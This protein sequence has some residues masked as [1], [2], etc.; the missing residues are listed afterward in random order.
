LPT[1]QLHRRQRGKFGFNFQ[2]AM[3]VYVRILAALFAPERCIDKSLGMQRAQGMPGAN[4]THG[5]VCE[6]K[7][8]YEQRHHRSA[9][10]IR[11]SLRDGLRLMGEL[12]SVS[13]TF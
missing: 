4:R 5:P 10:T 2:T 12:S 13:M 6:M 7:K 11:H 8:A 1:L 9:E 3:R